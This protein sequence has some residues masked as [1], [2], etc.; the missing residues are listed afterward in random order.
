MSG[1][2]DSEVGSMPSRAWS[3][4]SLEEGIQ[5]AAAAAGL[6]MK[7]KDY[8]E[9]GYPS[10]GCYT[11][12]HIDSHQM[13]YYIFLIQVTS[14]LTSPHAGHSSC[15]ASFEETSRPGSWAA[16][17]AHQNLFVPSQAFLE[18]NTGVI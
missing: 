8:L 3:C 14:A 5:A 16:R 9:A 18:H 2:H 13:I 7:T 6:T 12:A 1:T 4:Q 11:H 17:M 15:D 10:K